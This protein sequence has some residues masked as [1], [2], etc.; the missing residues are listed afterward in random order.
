MQQIRI[1]GAREHNLKTL[2]L[3]LPRDSL[4]VITGLSGSGK[5]SLAFDT[6]YAEGQRRYVES[7]SAYARQ[8][9]ELMQKPEVES[10]EGL[11]PAISIEQKTTSRNPRSTV[12]TVTEIYDYMRLLWAR[13]GIPYSPATGLPIVSQTVSQ[14]VDRVLAMPE[15]TRLYLLAPIVRGRKGEYRKELAELQKR[16]FQRVKIDG[17]MFDLDEVRPL[18]K[19][20]KHDIEIV[21]DRLVA[22]ADQGSRLAD[23]F[24]TALSLA[25]GIAVAEN[26]QS[27]ERTIFSAKFAC[28]VS[29]F[30]IPEI[31]PRLFSFNNPHGACPACDGLGEKLYFDP[32]LVVHDDRKSLAEGAV[33]PWSHS[34]SPYYLQTLEAIARHFKQSV[35]TPWAELPKK[36]R[37][38]ILYGSGGDPI[39][40]AYDDGFRQYTTERPFEGVLPNL[41]RRYRETDS[42]WLREELG[43]YQNARTC[44]VCNGDRLKPEA[45]AVKIAGKT[46]S[47]AA[48]LSIAEAAEWFAGI[49]ATLT[50]ASREIAER[51]LKEINERLG[52]LKNVGLEYLTLARA[53]GTLS[54]GESQRIRLASQIGSG[55]TGVLYVLDEP[56]IGLHQRDNDRLLAT[57]KRLRDL[58]NTVIVVE[59]DEEAIRAADW[60]V[61]MGPGAGV[62]GGHLVAEGPPEAI[63]AHP[64]SLTGQYLTGRRRIPLPAQRRLGHDGQILRIVGAAGNNLKGITAEIPLGTFCCVT[65]VSGGGK[66]TLIVETLYKALA[67]QLNNARLVPAPF[68]RL[69]GVEFLDKIV[70]IDQ[71]PIGRTPRSN[72]A[73]YTGCFTPIRDWYAGLPEAKARGYLPG[74]FSF[75]VKGGRC[76]ACQGDGVIKIEM[77]FLPDVYVQ[78]D[79]CHGRRYNR[80]T[81]EVL[82]RGKSIADVLDMTVDEGAQFFGAVPAIRDK[83]VTLQRVG[84]G[85]IKIGQPATT[86]S[87]GEAQRVKLAKELSRR[88]TGRTLYIL[89]E[90]TTGLHFEDVKKLLE[91]LHAL[92]AAG[93]T[94]LVIEH[95]L[96]V[97]KTADWIIDLGPEGGDRGGHIV[98]T[99]TPEEIAQCDASYTG[100]YL[101]PYLARQQAPARRRA[102]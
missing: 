63:M 74:R 50:P 48:R 100:Q 101:R 34:S 26:A 56:S 87:G 43:R 88:A 79:V 90:P 55:L 8:F 51:I 73:T 94:V 37:H 6:I 18:N 31:E 24:E 102:G 66:S 69:E 41:E 7:L 16:G 57:L 52:F 44:E 68:E 62:A 60:V 71:S 91:V 27:G 93:N 46:I 11:S 36:M 58:G 20:L 14:M 47:E 29:G 9:L 64:D 54:G 49:A 45:L 92:V 39:A 95:N 99:G 78:C 53:S 70:D 28:P 33:S 4:I 5:S 38:T 61:D 98:A 21:V 65:G 42:A 97:V 77:H 67:R 10:I 84:L 75:N 86:L 96:E 17:K 80:E 40:I 35:H 13:V 12:G 15:G 2:D 85:Y 76:E 59:H 81:L 23:S 1:R 32:D 72:P 19:N 25:D 22:A 83:L 89:D 30:T 3:D 82:F